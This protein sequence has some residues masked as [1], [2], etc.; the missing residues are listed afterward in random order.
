VDL[1]LGADAAGEIYLL[2]KTDGVIRRLVR[3]K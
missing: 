1:H 2:S 3:S